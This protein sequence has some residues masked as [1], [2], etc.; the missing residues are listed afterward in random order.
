MNKS[1]FKE[2]FVTSIYCKVQIATSMISK[3][4]I[5][6][7][8]VIGGVLGSYHQYS[9]CEP[10]RKEGPVTMGVL[11]GLAGTA[12]GA[13]IAAVPLVSIPIIGTIGIARLH[14]RYTA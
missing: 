4:L 2:I 9:T 10:W 7:G 12:Y 14:A 13:M 1:T 5:P 6:I 11:G 8:S 3:K